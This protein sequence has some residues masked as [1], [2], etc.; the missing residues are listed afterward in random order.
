LRILFS[1]L[2]RVARVRQILDIREWEVTVQGFSFFPPPLPHPAGQ[3]RLAI[4]LVLPPGVPTIL[5]FGGT[6]PISSTSVRISDCVV[7][8][9]DC[10]S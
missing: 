10:T 1:L 6:Q 9:M 2:S 8:G 7:Y 4:V 5:S 3:A